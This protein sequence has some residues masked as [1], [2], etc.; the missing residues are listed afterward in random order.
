[1]QRGFSRL[2]EEEGVISVVW[3]LWEVEFCDL[4]ILAQKPTWV[5][6]YGLYIST[7]IIGREITFTQLPE[8]FKKARNMIKYLGLSYEKNTYMS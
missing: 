1:M 2:Y 5:E 4:V 7:R 3:E 8:F 6:W